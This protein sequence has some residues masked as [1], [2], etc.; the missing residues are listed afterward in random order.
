MK[1][2]ENV[3]VE[4]KQVSHLSLLI[5]SKG[6]HYHVLVNLLFVMDWCFS[7]SDFGWLNISPDMLLIEYLGG[8]KNKKYR[9]VTCV[10]SLKPYMDI[11]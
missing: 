6:I 9:G 5:F 8:P 1:S 10:G 3:Y 4:L 2:F 7:L 11:L